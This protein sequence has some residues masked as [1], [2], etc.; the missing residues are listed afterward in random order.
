MSVLPYV[1][2]FGEKLAPG[3]SEAIGNVA[4]GFAQRS[5]KRAWEKFI[6]HEAASVNSSQPTPAGIS[7]GLNQMQQQTPAQPG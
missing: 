5:N 1:P 4:K 3:I 2:S 6:S 7:D